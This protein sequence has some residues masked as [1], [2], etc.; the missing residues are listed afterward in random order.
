LLYTDG[1]LDSQN[2]NRDFLGEEGMLDIIRDQLGS[3]AQAVQDALLS[4]IYSFAGSE[5]QVDDITIMTLVRDK[6]PRSF[7]DIVPSI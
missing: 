1:V 7:E 3:S 4:G 2:Q 6:T 5:P